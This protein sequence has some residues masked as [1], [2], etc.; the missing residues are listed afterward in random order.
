MSPDA[1][2][3]RYLA[4]VVFLVAAFAAGAIGSAATFEN[5]KTWYPTL[6]KPAWTPPSTLFAPVWTA[7]YALMAIA[8]WRAWRVSLPGNAYVTGCLY[9]LQLALNALW[10]ICFFGLKRPGL[11]LVDIVLLWLLLLAL[12]VRLW[13]KDRLAGL[14]WAP[15]LAWVTFASALNASIW[16]LN[17]G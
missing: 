8:A 15:Y 10:S 7:L 4:L 9:G 1:R 16:W 17:R 14:L 5:V 3:P 6:A 11:A 2:P 12:L 13:R